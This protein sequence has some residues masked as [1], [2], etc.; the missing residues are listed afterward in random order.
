MKTAGNMIIEEVVG[1]LSNTPPFKH[2]DAPLIGN[3]ASG[4][5]MEFYPKGHIILQQGGPA[6]D[7]MSIIKK[8]GVKVFVKTGEDEDILVDYIGEGESFGLLSVVS[9]GMSHDTVTAAEDTVCYSIKKETVLNLMDT[10]AVFSSF[11]LKSFFKKFIDISYKE[12]HDRSLLYGGGDKLLFTNTLSDIASR[13]VIT[14]SKDISIKEAADKMSRHKIS[15]LVI[16]DSDG[17]PAGVVTDKDLRIKVTAKGRDVSEPVGNIMSVTLI[18]AEAGDYCFEALLKMIRY[19]IHHLL[20]V[21]RGDIM[22]I[23]TGHDLMMMQGASPLSVAREIENQSTSDGLIPVSKKI[24][25]II[26]VLI[27]EEA[28]ASNITRIITEINDRLVR[29]LLEITEKRLGPPPVNYCWI[30]F[31]SEGR[32]EQT[33]RTDQDNAIIYADP[34][35][36]EDKV[37]KY[38]LDLAL[39]MKDALVKC[40]FPTCR[41]DYMASNPRWRRPLKVW[42]GYFSR[43]INTPTPE[44]ILSSLIFF[45]LRPVH[46]DFTLA[47]KLRA[48][49]GSEIRNQKM[50]LAHMAGTILKNRPPLGLFGR[51]ALEKKGDQKGAVN[52]KMNGLGPIID[53]ARLCALDMGVYNTSTI[54][55][56]NDIKN[57]HSAITEFC[58]ELAQSFEFLMSLRLRH[59][60]KQIESGIE[61]DNFINPK[62]LGGLDRKM[63]KESFRLVSKAQESIKRQYGAW[64]LS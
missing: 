36:D 47:E 60:Y 32:K 11:Y 41:A 42:K 52:I 39:Y 5:L 3:I 56:L 27:K 7:C 16:L 29:K 57:R 25:K 23:I 55:R 58:D 2:L 15:S 44:A 63:L 26:T 34:E 53:A 38:F 9:G 30:V 22:G 62:T 24:N 13:E 48:Y 12:I 64:M 10:N 8:G 6:A 4:V 1:F 18:K 45:D 59:Q 43:W 14:A 51:F 50:F 46:G 40:G 31:G 28:K 17:F 19:N 61:S 21:N 35:K 20:V 37:E 49:L 54:E 33:F